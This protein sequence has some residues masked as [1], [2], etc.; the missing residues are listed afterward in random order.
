M[1][2]FTELKI[3]KKIKFII[4]KMSDDN[5]EIVVEEASENRDWDYFR[6]KLINAKTKNKAVCL[7][8]SFDLSRFLTYP[9]GKEGKGPRYAVYDFNYDL[10]SG[11][12]TRCVQYLL[13]R[14]ENGT[15]A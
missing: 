10:A 12:G 6:Q 8:F 15:D 3:N 5:R 11:E 2:K 4:Y 7:S 14:I 13:M 1:S 9:Q